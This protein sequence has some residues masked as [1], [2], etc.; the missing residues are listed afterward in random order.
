MTQEKRTLCK[1]ENAHNIETLLHSADGTG[2]AVRLIKLATNFFVRHSPNNGVTPRN[3]DDTR[4][5]MRS[6]Y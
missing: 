2:E 4:M 3:N 6:S 5:E 1:Y